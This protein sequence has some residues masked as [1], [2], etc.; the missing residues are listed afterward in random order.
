MNELD[1]L[2]YQKKLQN[3][4]NSIELVEAATSP[5]PLQ[6]TE[7]LQTPVPPVLSPS[8]TTT[9]SPAGPL[10]VEEKAKHIDGVEDSSKKRNLWILLIVAAVL[11][12][13]L[14]LRLMKAPSTIVS[15]ATQTQTQS[16]P[17]HGPV[18]SSGDGLPPLPGGI[19]IYTPNDQMSI[20]R[21]DEIEI[22]IARKTDYLT[23]SQKSCSNMNDLT[24]YDRAVCKI[25][26]EEKYFECAPDG[27]R[28]S[29]ECTPGLPSGKN[30]GASEIIV[31]DPIAADALMNREDSILAATANSVLENRKNTINRQSRDWLG[32]DTS[33]LGITVRTLEPV[34]PK[35]WSSG[36][37][38][39]SPRPEEKIADIRG[40][41]QARKHDIEKANLFAVQIPLSVSA[42]LASQNEVS[43]GTYELIFSE[44][45]QQL[46]HG[47]F[48]T[49]NILIDE[50]GSLNIRMNT[51]LTNSFF[52]TQNYSEEYFLKFLNANLQG[53]A[54]P[55]G[56]VISNLQKFRSSDKLAL[57]IVFDKVGVPTSRYDADGTTN[58]II[59]NASAKYAFLVNLDTG[60]IIDGGPKGGMKLDNFTQEEND[61]RMIYVGAGSCSKLRAANHVATSI[62]DECVL[63]KTNLKT[64]SKDKEEL[65]AIANRSKKV[66]K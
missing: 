21:G 46:N 33:M 47:D 66:T 7:T 36:P 38:Q 37:V 58:R 56:I 5:M 52:R 48:S 35:W 6:P 12:G 45:L 65:D 39:S 9:E 4:T 11:L 60:E 55:A 63:K 24:E 19:E 2:E 10:N 29:T 23:A 53:A 34:A 50:D 22:D 20:I 16:A 41:I 30:L 1:E 18:S 17:T 61:S 15:E 59:L 13:A 26:G 31:L 25:V 62:F 64:I 57:S 32:N 43:N 8:T 27:K 14:A 28:Y 3:L 49:K 51:K 44:L 42:L 54:V 40:L